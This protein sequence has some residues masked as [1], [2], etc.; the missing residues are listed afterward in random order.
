MEYPITNNS[1]HKKSNLYHMFP[2]HCC[3]TCNQIALPY[4]T[5]TSCAATLLMAKAFR[6]TNQ[7]SL[8]TADAVTIIILIIQ[9]VEQKQNDN[10]SFQI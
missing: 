5:Q 8:A 9:F 3:L 4:F 7:L 2:N 1:I 10:P 6:W